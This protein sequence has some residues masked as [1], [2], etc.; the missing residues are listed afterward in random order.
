MTLSGPRLGHPVDPQL[1]DNH[2]YGVPALYQVSPTA[3]LCIANIRVIGAGQ[4]DFENGADAIVFDSLD[5]IDAT[6]A[7][8]LVRNVAVVDPD[9][10]TRL[11]M[12]M[13]AP[14]GGFVPLG[15]V[16][17]DGRPHPAA[18]TG[19]GIAVASRHYETAPLG[20]TPTTVKSSVRGYL[21]LLQYRYDGATFTVVSSRRIDHADF[22]P[23]W[24]TFGRGLA[25]AIPD[26]EDLL[27]GLVAGQDND[28]ARAHREL[29]KQAGRPAHPHAHGPLGSCYGSVCSR[30]RYGK[31][32]WQPVSYAP[33]SAVGPDMAGEPSMV[34]DLD[35]SILFS[36][37]GKGSN[38]APGECDL[39]LENTYEH[40]R[41]YRSRDNG[42]TW[43]R[44]IHLAEVRSPTPV[45]INC[46][47]NGQP[48]LAANPFKP[49]M[50]DDEGRTIY[51][52]RVREELMA[53]ALTPDRRGVEKPVM[54]LDANARFGKAR[55]YPEIGHANHWHL[56][57]PEGGVI[58]LR[59]GRW[60]AL[61]AFRFTDTALCGF[62]IPP[63]PQAGAWIEEIECA[64]EA[65]APWRFS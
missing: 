60:H 20:A 33:V 27:F 1:R 19:F 16:L 48:Y 24:L 65:R 55:Q 34:R 2:I 41:V 57:H 54:L 44:A 31:D 32:G 59:D 35:G 30:W 4:V 47:A 28:T 22:F 12:V 58:R 5:A 53:W 46:L 21:I 26:G 7:V 43:E 49:L 51:K 15:A 36:V 25:A 50:K 3:A 11:V 38:A 39:G 62:G 6:K 45:V 64:G 52:T 63:P 10:G 29:V 17:P 18:G 13:H 14:N 23:G 40:F 56:D 42:A 8:P 61:L 37:R 9:N